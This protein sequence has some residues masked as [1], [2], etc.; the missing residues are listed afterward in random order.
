M[1]NPVQKMLCSILLVM[2]AVAPGSAQQTA[3]I[4]TM[5]PMT[6]YRRKA[7]RATVTLLSVL[8][9]LALIPRMA[10]AHSW[11]PKECC[12][13][14]DCMLAD[15]IETD[16]RGDRIVIVGDRRILISPS[17]PVRSSPDGHVHICFGVFAGPDMSAHAVDYVFCLFLPA[18]S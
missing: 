6:G 3:S 17:L 13:N 9:C 18:Q 7:M 12:S 2:V 5:A 15:R 11:Y 1:P 10:G 8:G 14:H 4:A 16:A